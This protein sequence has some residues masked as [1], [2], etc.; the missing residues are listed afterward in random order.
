MLQKGKKVEIKSKEQYPNKT[1]WVFSEDM[2][3]EI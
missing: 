2:L 1:E 3:E